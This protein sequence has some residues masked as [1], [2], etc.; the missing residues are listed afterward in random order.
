MLMMKSLNVMD[1]K[2]KK[3][4]LPRKTK[5]KLKKDFFTYP[6]SERNTYLLAWPYKYEEDYMAYKKGLLRGLKEESKKRYK[7]ERKRDNLRSV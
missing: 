5:K 7:D 4:R 3:F 2:K 1:Q 6:K